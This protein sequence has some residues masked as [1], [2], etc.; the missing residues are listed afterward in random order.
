MNKEFFYKKIDEIFSDNKSRKVF[1]KQVDNYLSLK[2]NINRI[3]I[4]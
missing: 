1:K 3:N 4:V 2:D